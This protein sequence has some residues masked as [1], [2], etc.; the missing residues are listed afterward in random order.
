MFKN[1]SGHINIIKGFKVVSFDNLAID[2]LKLRRIFSNKD[3]NEFYM[4]DDGQF[5]MY[6]DLVEEK[7]ALSSTSIE[8]FEIMDDIVDMFNVVKSL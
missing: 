7:Y 4:G 1:L 8:R 6:I 5:T 3:W 2:Q